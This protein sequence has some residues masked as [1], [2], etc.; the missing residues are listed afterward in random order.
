MDKEYTAGYTAGYTQR[1]TGRQPA[2]TGTTPR[3]QEGYRHGLDISPN[4]YN[5]KED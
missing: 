5:Y 1:L 3:W 4:I 2:T